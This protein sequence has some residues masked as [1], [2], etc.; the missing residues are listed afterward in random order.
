M[1]CCIF[2]LLLSFPC[3]PKGVAAMQLQC[4]VSAPQRA[5]ASR[6][7]R[8]DSGRHHGRDEFRPRRWNREHSASLPSPPSSSSAADELCLRC[9]CGLAAHWR[10]GTTAQRQG[11]TSKDTGSRTKKGGGIR[12]HTQRQSA[13]TSHRCCL[14]ASP[15]SGGGAAANRTNCLSSRPPAAV[16]NGDG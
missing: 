6:A 4:A 10:G 2:Y 1:H 9:G 13:H 16:V 15:I 3:V 11:H 12:Y 5:R 14:R 8:T 7:K